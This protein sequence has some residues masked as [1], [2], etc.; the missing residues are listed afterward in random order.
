MD[1]LDIRVS[2]RLKTIMKRLEKIVRQETGEELGL[3]LVIFPWT[4]D[5]QPSRVAEFQYISNAPR[6][7]M[8]GVLKELIGKWDGGMVDVPPHEKQ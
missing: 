1:S 5:G 6:P 4:R 7:Y 8:H 2:Q 3:G